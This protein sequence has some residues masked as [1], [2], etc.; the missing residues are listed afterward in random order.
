MFRFVNSGSILV[1]ATLLLSCSVGSPV[2]VITRLT[3][4]TGLHAPLAND[5]Y[6]TGTFGEFR[7]A[8]FHYGIDLGCF[9]GTPV[10]A[11]RS[12]YIKRFMYQRYGIGFGL[13]IA[14]KNETTSLYGHLDSLNTSLLEHPAFDS[15]REKINTRTEFSMYMPKDLIQI[16]K[17]Q[18]IAV[19]GDTGSGPQH[20]HFE[21]RKNDE[22]LNPLNYGLSVPDESNLHVEFLSLLPAN[23][24]SRINGKNKELRIPISKRKK[25]IE[26]S[27]KSYNIKQQPRVYGKVKVRL[28]AYDPERRARLG[29]ASGALYLD[30]NLRFRFDFDRMQRLPIY[31]HFLFYDH[32]YSRLR[33]RAR[34]MHN[35]HGMSN[36]SIPFVQANNNGY[37]DSDQIKS[38]Q[39]LQLVARDVSGKKSQVTLTLK[40]DGSVY[41]VRENPNSINVYADQT[42]VLKSIDNKFQVIVQHDS[43]L[44]DS[45]LFAKKS[46]S[47]FRYPRGIK[48]ISNM[49]SLTSD[50]DL[51]IAPLLISLSGK[52]TKRSRL[53]KVTA[54][55][56][57]P[58]VFSEYEKGEYRFQ[59]RLPGNFQILEDYVAPKIIKPRR[60]YYRRNDEAHYPFRLFFKIKDIGAGVDYQNVQVFVDDK[61][62]LC[63][64]NG[65]MDAMEILS[66]QSI[67]NRG[68][69]RV[70]VTA[71]DLDG[72]RAQKTGF[73]YFVR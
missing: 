71:N 6:L 22:F 65:D 58:V 54:K 3:E 68:W 51:F 41:K 50:E 63:E 72:N 70:R 55:N 73:S 13:I 1:V 25:I 44:R 8:H 23:K 45:R 56:I 17:G 24:N 57:Y 28:A 62:A 11:A 64:H 49:Y 42:M 30:G 37:I 43:L 53:Y 32:H 19:S 46:G 7:N 61:K 16:K 38:S 26:N 35:Y 39:K 52:K 18:M 48:K 59:T 31:S 10:Y 69:H 15:V 20:L 21:L 33:Y 40:K 34:Y 67:Y 29:L 4:D 2:D 9:I 47:G 27:R 60:K 5:L 14:H 66:P 12:G 36:H